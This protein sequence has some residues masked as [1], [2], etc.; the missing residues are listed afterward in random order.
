MIACVNRIT[1]VAEH[2]TSDIADCRVR[3]PRLTAKVGS[4]VTLR[5]L[6]NRLSYSVS[7]RL[8]LCPAQGRRAI[9]ANLCDRVDKKEMTAEEIFGCRGRAND[10]SE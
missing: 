5:I 10:A 6:T 9:A 4:L 8:I 3:C 7:I 2:C 1:T